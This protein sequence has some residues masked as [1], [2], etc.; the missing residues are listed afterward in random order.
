M[1]RCKPDEIRNKFPGDSE[2]DECR[3]IIEKRPVVSLEIW[4]RWATQQLAWGRHGPEVAKL[5]DFL[6]VV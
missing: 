3:H 2:S 1:G 6:R 4:Q 5:R